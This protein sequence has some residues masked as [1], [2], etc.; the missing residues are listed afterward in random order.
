[1]RLLPL[2]LLVLIAACQT[3]TPDTVVTPATLDDS[4]RALIDQHPEATVAVAVRDAATG[5]NVDINADRLFHA[6]STMKVPVMI[7]VYRRAEAGR[8]SLD[9]ALLVKNEFR[10]IVDSSLYSIEDDSDDAIYE[11]LGERMAI[12]DLVV[13]MI[14][15]SSNLATNL[16]IDHLDADSVQ[17]TI[18]R[19]GTEQME[20]LRGVEDIKAYRQGLSN[21][22]TAAD[23]ALLLDRLQQGTAVAPA[24]DSAMVAV[25]L[26]QQ[27]NDMI[28][29]GLPAGTRVAHKTGSITEIHHDAALV[30]PEDG[31]PYVLV[32]LTEGIADRD[33][34]ARLGAEITR[35]VHRALRG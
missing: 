32:V 26:D 3:N 34:S 8:L 16:L 7:E 25:L 1:M 21:Q 10:S 19:L 28:P 5:T 35:L 31:A 2:V 29:A 23:L 22:A 13:Q 18:E 27:F 30:Y 15:V 9:D 20:V 14:T 11:R 24:A 4:L 12:R 17:A 33:D 6:A